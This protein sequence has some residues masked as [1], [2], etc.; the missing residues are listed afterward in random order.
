MIMPRK[1]SGKKNTK[2]AMKLFELEMPLQQKITEYM[3]EENIARD[4][5]RSQPY[6]V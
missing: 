1:K 6:I 3:F 4:R 2:Q 5:K